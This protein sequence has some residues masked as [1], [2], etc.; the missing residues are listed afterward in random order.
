MNA[1]SFMRPIEI[2]GLMLLKRLRYIHAEL[3]CCS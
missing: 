1:I 3:M 2:M